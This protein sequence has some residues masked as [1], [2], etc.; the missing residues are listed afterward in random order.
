MVPVSRKKGSRPTV[1]KA[2]SAQ[3]QPRKRKESSPPPWLLAVILTGLGAGAFWFF[4]NQRIEPGDK[5]VRRELVRILQ[6][7]PEAEALGL[8][9]EEK[10]K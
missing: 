4:S 1:R 9:P 7:N 6:E 10:K 3:R 5:D 8:A 2:T